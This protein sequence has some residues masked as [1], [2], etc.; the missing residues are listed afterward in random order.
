VNVLLE[1]AVRTAEAGNAPVLVERGRDARDGEG[2]REEQQADE[3]DRYHVV[4][5]HV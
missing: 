5:F 3:N 2:E 4:P 1:W